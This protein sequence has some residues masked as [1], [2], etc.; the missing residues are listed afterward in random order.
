M[1]HST[2]QNISRCGCVER[3]R[4]Q[5]YGGGCGNYADGLALVPAWDRKQPERAM[6]EFTCIA[7]WGYYVEHWGKPI[8]G[9]TKPD[10]WPK[11]E[12]WKPQI[13]EQVNLA[14]MHERENERREHE[15]KMREATIDLDAPLILQKGVEYTPEQMKQLVTLSRATR[16]LRASGWRG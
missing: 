10:W 6:A 7:C 4:C 12:P 2:P 13:V 11:D 16:E 5:M 8:P 3:P 9:F 14:L 1:I 15:R